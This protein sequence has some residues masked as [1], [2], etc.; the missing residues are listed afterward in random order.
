MADI[1]KQRKNPKKDRYLA[2]NVTDEDYAYAEQ[3]DQ[4][5][6]AIVRAIQRQL[7]AASRVMVNKEKIAFTL[8]TDDYRYTFITPPD[9]VENVIKPFDMGEKPK[10]YSFQLVNPISANPV[11]HRT[12][13]ERAKHRLSTRRSNAL[14]K[15][16]SK[17]PAVKNYNR[18]I[19]EQV[20]NE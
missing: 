9:A 12:V 5:A 16:N 18:F 3:Q 8:D 1:A 11:V 13:E 14:R 4:W 7:P 6:C 20:E 15:H 19:S 2:V 10:P 17:S